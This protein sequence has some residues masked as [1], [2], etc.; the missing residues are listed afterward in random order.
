MTRNRFFDTI[1]SH[2]VIILAFVLVFSFS[3]FCFTACGKNN[4]DDK[5][6]TKVEHDESILKNGSFEF[7]SAELEIDEY[8]QTTVTGWSRAVDNGA[9]S[10]KVDSG[11]IDTSEKGW[12]ALMS[13]LYDDSDFLSFVADKYGFDKNDIF[14]EIKAENPDAKTSEINAMV[15]DR[16]L[17]G[18]NDGTQDI[19]Y[20]GNLVN[21]GTHDGKDSKVYM[22]NN[23][24]TSAYLG[25][26]TAQKLTS[27][28]TIDMEAGSYAKISFWVKVQNFTGYNKAGANV[29]L[30]NKFNSV[31]QDEYALYGITDTEWTKYTLYVKADDTYSCSLQVVLGFG[32]GNGSSTA[33]ADYA[34]GTAYFDDVVYEVIDEAT[35]NNE[36]GI[37]AE[38][39]I[40]NFSATASTDK[41]FVNAKELTDANKVPF[42][43]MDFDASVS[44]Y[45]PDYIETFNLSDATIEQG[46]TYSHVTGTAETILGAQN[47]NKGTVSTL[48]NEITV[49]GIKN[50]AYNLKLS[51]SKFVVPAESYILLSF[52]IKNDLGN[53]DTN[54]IN[55]FVNDFV[56]TTENAPV[57]AVTSNVSG[58]ETEYS[59]LIKNNFPELDKKGLYIKERTFALTI[60]IGPYDLSQN[61]VASDFATGDVTISD[62]KIAT[63]KTYEFERTNYVK[64]GDNVVSY[65]ISSSNK[66]ENYGLYTFLAS[67]ANSTVSLYA[68]ESA[69]YTA[70]TNTTF[71]VSSDSSEYGT[72]VS[73]PAKVSGYTGIVSKHSY[74]DS[75]STIYDIDT[76]SGN[77]DGE[78][79][80]GVIN[81]KYLDNYTDNLN[82]LDGLKTALNHTG[83]T[84][85]QPIMIYNSA[86][87]SYGYIGKSITTPSGSSN[88]VSLDVRV[89]GDA[90]AYIYL[91][92]TDN[93]EKEVMSINVL[94]N[95]DGFNDITPTTPVNKKLMLEITSDMMNKTGEKQGWLTV[96][97]YLA[98]GTL[99][100][101][102]RLEMWN[103]G[104]DGS[105]E[106]ASEGYVFFDN[107][108]TSK[109]FNEPTMEEAFSSPDSILYNLTNAV[110]Y[111]RPL[112][113]KEI[114]FNNKQTNPENKISYDAK[115]IWAE[116]DSTIY[117][118]YN[119]IEP[120]PVEPAVEDDD[121]HEGA[122]CTAT[123]DP[124]T[125]WMSFSSIVLAAA[126]LL[127]LVM[128]IVKRIRERNKANKSDAKSYY[129]VTSR[130]KEKP[131]KKELKKA[132]K[133]FIDTDEEPVV[134]EDPVADEVIEEEI[135][136]EVLD[137]STKQDES[138][139]QTLDDYVYGEVESFG[140]EENNDAE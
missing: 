60:Y 51:S 78:S 70:P 121:E 27:S 37:K 83:N 1:K 68:G 12:S 104:R 100:K 87:S 71:T 58:E 76:L 139:E 66:T 82:G 131:T 8:P 118:I 140:N 88:V 90:K 129:K 48:N 85:I 20:F 41:I 38:A 26:G 63:G 29:R 122:G 120:I 123:T 49:S 103:G 108:V 25:Y 72:I 109:T 6:Y 56:G 98:T 24:R 115:Y 35:F 18:Y 4:D 80:A 79:H 7:G 138:E 10:S 116:N 102:Y 74:I 96:T 14:N 73:A 62:F 59:I 54:G 86:K 132:K 11:I 44:E 21:P 17:N 2:L 65:V 125:F 133:Q 117:A 45:Y 114:A 105:T 33:A 135:V 127:A 64:D 39:T 110:L 47:V 31:A 75:S 3:L 137:E 9:Y 97:F 69:N 77:I 43:S 101:E 55:V 134:D 136:E 28:T 50:L 23:Y 52:K 89:V 30:V 32:F 13:T 81:T 67:K 42:Y 128:L 112:D 99:A 22:L 107:I 84:D 15:K 124:S 91:V 36:A 94:S 61:L 92:A 95:T 111:K 93:A 16:I 34:E 5:S 53:F 46:L 119:S 40:M 106:T 113:A 57:K 130:Y 126:L 19:K